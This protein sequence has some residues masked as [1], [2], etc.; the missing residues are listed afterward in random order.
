MATFVSKVEASLNVLDSLIFRLA[1]LNLGWSR[2]L[3]FL[4]VASC[5][6]KN[7]SLKSH[8]KINALI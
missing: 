7:Q 1:A 2:I 4:D 8:N 6:R 3:I 5:S